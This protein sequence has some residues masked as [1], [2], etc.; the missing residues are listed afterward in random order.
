MRGW[1]WRTKRQGRFCG[2]RVGRICFLYFQCSI[3]GFS[4]FLAVHCQTV[5]WTVDHGLWLMD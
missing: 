3:L 4:F 1:R 2:V 5:M